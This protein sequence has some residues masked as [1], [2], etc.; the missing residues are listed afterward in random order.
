MSFD[1]ISKSIFVT[2]TFAQAHPREH[3][4]L[5]KQF[6]QEIPVKERSGVYGADNMAYIK[7]LRTQNNPIVNNFLKDNIV[8]KSY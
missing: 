6:E 8:Q 5:W 7:W 3:V 2:N 4:V 1:A